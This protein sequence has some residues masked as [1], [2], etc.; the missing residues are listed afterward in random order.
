[1][2]GYHTTL[3]HN[4]FIKSMEL[5]NKNSNISVFQFFTKNPRSYAI[6]DIEKIENHCKEYIEEKNFKLFTHGCYL[7]NSASKEKWDIKIECAWND[8]ECASKLGAIGTVFHVG[9]HVKLTKEEGVSN[10]Y[11]FISIQIG[12][13]QERDMSIQYILET[14]AGCGTELLSNIQELGEFYHRF[15]MEQKKNIKICIDTCHVFSAGYAIQSKED[16]TS[17]IESVEKHIQWENVSLIHLNDCKKNVGCCVDRHE[18]IGKGY[19]MKDTMD[20]IFLLIQ[21]CKLYDIP[22]ILETPHQEY[23]MHEIHNQE[24]K[25]FN[26]Y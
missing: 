21:H 1:M 11:E 9:K 17:F 5:A 6:K 15:T 2:I 16:M 18:N 8:I 4:S 23:N 26:G 7:I 22:L 13:I 25:L 24:L 10:M 3:I 14:S 19:I 20:G 12:R